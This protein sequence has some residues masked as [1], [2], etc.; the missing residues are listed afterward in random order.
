MAQPKMDERK[1]AFAIQTGTEALNQLAESLP[2][3]ALDRLVA[4]SKQPYS[5]L[6]ELLV[7]AA[8]HA[9]QQSSALDRAAVR[10]LRVRQDLL[11]QEGGLASASELAT[12]FEPQLTRQAVDERRKKRQ[13]V[14]LEDGSGHFK[15]PVWQVHD[16]ASLP[17]LV[18]VI[19]ELDVADQMAVV[20]FFLQPDPRLKVKGRRPLDIARGGD[21][22][23]LLELARTFGEHGAL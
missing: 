7:E 8:P 3:E 16:G 4:K 11:A 23:L 2:A 13:L 12:F 22:K 15:Y 5:F 10:G 14:A 6:V 9:A 1:K 21:V 17:G 20:V 19:S 18:D